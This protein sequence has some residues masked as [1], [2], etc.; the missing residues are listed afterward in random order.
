MP[1]T[2]SNSTGRGDRLPSKPTR[3]SRVAADLRAAIIGGELEP[4]SK[5]NL[6]QLRGRLGVS[7]SPLREAISR[8]VAEHLV[9][10]EDQRG[11]R[12]APVSSGN[13][14]EC[15]AH[16]ADLESL[17][18]AR[19]ITLGD[20]EWE[21][22]LL[23]SLHRLA[24]ATPEGL[25]TELRDFHALLV[26]ACGQPMLAG[27]CAELFNLQ[28]R[29]R[30]LLAQGAVLEDAAAADLRAIAEAAVG[31][32]GELATALLRRHLTRSG[33]RLQALLASWKQDSGTG[34]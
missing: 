30:N 20:V 16:R 11:F 1:D 4:G 32:N 17:A 19:S 22:D 9:E 29:Y 25:E 8:L 3:A 12:I 2:A 7:L 27:Y 26:T 6:D 15:I 23:A 10:L 34:N 33:E 28:A 18:L 31:R 13:L 24:R 14:A 21:G 5:I